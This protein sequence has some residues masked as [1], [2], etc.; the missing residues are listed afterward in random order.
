MDYLNDRSWMYKFATKY[1]R[2]HPQFLSGVN[3]FMEFAKQNNVVGRDGLMLC[4]CAKCENKFYLD[5]QNIEYHIVREGFYQGYTFWRF[6]G[7]SKKRQREQIPNE[8]GHGSEMI[9]ML[10]NA[11]M[12]DVDNEGEALESRKFEQLLDEAKR[13][14]YQGSEKFSKLSFIELLFQLKCLHKWSNKSLSDVLALFK[15]ALP[16]D[17]SHT[18]ADIGQSSTFPE[19][20]E[21]DMTPETQEP[22]MTPETQEPDM[23][24]E[25]QEPDMALERRDQVMTPETQ[26]PIMM[27]VRRKCRGPA[28][29]TNLIPP[30]GEK[31]KCMVKNNQVIGPKQKKF[32]R[33]IGV[34]ARYGHYFPLHEQWDRE[35]RA[36]SVKTVMNHINDYY[37]FRYKQG[38]QVEQDVLE[39]IVVKELQE[40]MKCWRA[41]LKKKYYDV[42]DE[43]VRK[44]CQDAR[45]SQEQWDKLLEYWSSEENVKVAE[46]NKKNRAHNHVRHTLGTKSLA[47]YYE[48]ERER[49]G[50]EFTIL[51][52]YLSA[53]QKKNGEYPTTYTQEKCL[54]V[55]NVF[56]VNEMVASQD[57]KDLGPMLDDVFGR[58][59]GGYERGLGVGWNRVKMKLVAKPSLQ[60]H[61]L[62]N[63]LEIANSKISTLSQELQEMRE[64]EQPRETEMQDKEAKREVER[65][66]QDKATR[67]L[68]R[69]MQK[70]LLMLTKRVTGSLPKRGCI[71][72]S[73][74]ED[75]S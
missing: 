67:E 51:A 64:R 75:D 53:H 3:F 61:K 10:I 40:K 17:T 18:D 57:E 42:D 47:C 15:D 52:S 65:V 28:K 66:E 54:E 49:R 5:C 30:N 73:D 12:Q 74:S 14:L 20:Q 32:T 29:E 27:H 44:K 72:S 24:P 56:Q 59:H 31:W 7:E 60:M 45:V 6:H 23:T 13:H 2:R 58:H 21:P 22:D 9:M 1:S 43:E 37:E 19:T 55:A 46:K 38:G 8:T 34:Y 70:Q 16:M 36:A 48:E 26:E 11:F 25:T 62:T 33:Q 41:Y 68:M 63:E 35:K 4:P 69:R 39:S 50:N 71:S